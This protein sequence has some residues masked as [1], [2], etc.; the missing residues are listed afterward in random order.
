[1]DICQVL[2]GNEDGG[3]EKHTIELSKQLK[4]KNI[5]VTVIAHKDFSSHFSDLNFIPL[6]LAKGRKNIFILI[7]LY[8]ILKNGNFDIVHSQANKATAMVSLI[9]PFL[10]SSKFISTLHSSKRNLKVFEKS[11][12]VITVSN[13]ISEKLRNVNKRTIYNGIKYQKLTNIDDVYLKYSIPKNKF[14]ISSVGR[15]CDIKRFDI[16]INSLKDLDVFCIIIGD[17]ENKEQL[18]DLAKKEG[19]EKQLLF[20]GNINNN[21]VKKILTISKL[22]V[23]TS[24]KEGF[25]Y[26]FIESLLYKTPIISTDVSDIKDIIGKEYIFDFNSSKQLNIKIKKIQDNYENELKNYEKIFNFSQNK[27][28]LENMIE[29]TIEVY[30]NVLK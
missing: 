22:L 5:N 18:C 21:D 4:L 7:D 17:G 6:D 30:K 20:T 29:E 8:K 9:K 10:S 24:D 3:L 14:L 19:V 11:D 16:L 27:F 1:M 26:V 13:K 12:F 25:P 2:A 28:L 15:L 23:I